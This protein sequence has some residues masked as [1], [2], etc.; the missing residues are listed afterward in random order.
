MKTENMPENSDD[1]RKAEI[2]KDI[3]R[4]GAALSTSE[5]VSR[6]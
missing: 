3:V 4:T 6:H 5:T 2:G 1:S